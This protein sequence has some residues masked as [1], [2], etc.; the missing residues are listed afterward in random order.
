MRTENIP[1]VM[2]VQESLNLQPGM[3]ND[4]GAGEE[5]RKEHDE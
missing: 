3:A 4:T 1:V 2:S 5:R